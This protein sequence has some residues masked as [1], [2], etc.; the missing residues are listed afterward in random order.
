M[1]NFMILALPRTAT[2]WAANWLTTDNTLCLHDPLN[3]WHY[4]ALDGL[5]SRRRVGVSCTGL[6]NFTDW[7]ND[8]PA[9]K[10]ILHRDMSEINEELRRL[11][12]PEIT[13]A[14]KL[15]LGRI[16]GLHCHYSDLFK[17]PAPIYERLL[18]VPFDQERHAELC[19]IAMQPR[20]EG[21]TY[22]PAVIR[23]LV[24]EINQGA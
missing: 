17:N 11:G 3:N 8:H 21:L 23:R 15:K 13:K 12:M 16:K 14:D 22:N 10:V 1:L 19:Q 7:L 24:S 20:F 6:Y 4:T 5:E 18:G 2:T 9:P